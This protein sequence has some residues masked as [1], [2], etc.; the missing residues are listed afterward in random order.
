MR[1][2]GWL[3]VLL[4]LLVP[5]WWGTDG[6]D[7][8]DLDGIAPGPTLKAIR[9]GFG[10]RWDA[11]YGPLQYPP[12]SYYLVALTYVPA[13]AVFKVTGELGV[14]SGTYPWGF[15][16]PELSMG[17]LVILGRLVAVLAALAIV[18]LAIADLRS[19]GIRRPP[20]L[21]GLLL[22]G[23]PVFVYYART[24]NVD[25]HYLFWLWLGFV[26]V[27]HRPATPRHLAWAG[28]AAAL[29]ICTKEQSAP[30]RG[31]HPRGGRDRAPGDSRRTAGPVDGSGSC[32]HSWPPGS[33][34]GSSG[35]CR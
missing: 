4:V 32:F 1:R 20:V 27:E 21:V 35:S 2:L 18:R 13:L 9:S 14:P 7:P 3:I 26:L 31:D 17:L 22:I 11:R 34:T 6:K 33:P 15:S 8:W 28:S 10:P 29:A 25:M 12:A 23:S 30:H 24:S 16:H 5:I 19:R